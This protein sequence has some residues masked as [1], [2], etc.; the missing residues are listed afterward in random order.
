MDPNQLNLVELEW[1]RT[2]KL[3]IGVKEIPGEGHRDRILEY[4]M[5]TGL[6]AHDDETPWC[7]SFVN[8]CLKQNGFRGT[9]SAKALSWMQWGMPSI[10]QYGAITVLS[11]G[12]PGQGHVAFLVT[13]NEKQVLLLGGNQNN[14]VCQIWYPISRVLGYRWMSAK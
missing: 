4:H 7:S 11:R 8:W 3:E 5:T 2:A 6:K 9:N 12:S 1:M 14:M 10:P 13:K